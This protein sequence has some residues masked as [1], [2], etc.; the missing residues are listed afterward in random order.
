[1]ERLLIF[2]V[3]SAHLRLE[4]LMEDSENQYCWHSEFY[5]VTNRSDLMLAGFTLKNV[6]STDINIFE[7]YSKKVDVSE[8]R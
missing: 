7:Y 2:K 5:K 1:M 6:V 8:K 3:N 4:M